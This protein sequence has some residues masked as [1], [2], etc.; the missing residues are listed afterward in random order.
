MFEKIELEAGYIKF[1]QVIDFADIHYIKVFPDFRGQGYGTKLM[2]A[3]LEEMKDRGV[4]DV[5]L[6]VRV[7]NLI[8]IKLY[9][10]FGFKAVGF[11]KKYYE[12]S[13]DGLLMKLD[14]IDI[15]N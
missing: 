11:R 7:D 10:K 2:N 14:L 1:H 8:A 6:E 15:K 12:G 3:F 9:E 4:K 13:T 5:T